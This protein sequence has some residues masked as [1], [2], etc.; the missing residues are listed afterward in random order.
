MPIS[1]ACE[2][3]NR[4]LLSEEFAGEQVNCPYCGRDLKPDFTPSS[5]PSSTSS[6]TSANA[7]PTSS[8]RTTNKSNSV[9]PP[10]L[11]GPTAPTPSQPARTPMGLQILIGFAV[12]AAICSAVFLRVEGPL[13]GFAIAAPAVLVALLALAM[14]FGARQSLAVS[15]VAF[16]F[17]STMASMTFTEPGVLDRL[18]AM[19]SN[20]AVDSETNRSE[21]GKPSGANDNSASKTK[22]QVLIKTN[23]STPNPDASVNSKT[24]G[25]DPNGVNVWSPS[26]ESIRR[27]DWEFR[28]T[29]VSITKPRV[30]NLLESSNKPSRWEKAGLLVQ[31]EV[32]N[33]SNSRR[34]DYKLFRIQL[35][36]DVRNRCERVELG[37][38]RLADRNILSKPLISPGQSLSDMFF[39]DEP[40][41]K[42][43]HLDLDI[44]AGH[45]D[46]GDSVRIRIP[47]GLIERESITEETPKP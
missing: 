40:G 18:I 28:L 11:Q 2:C 16:L 19:A 21:D 17:C 29:R 13:W 44:D 9:V 34:Y 46:F 8:A 1:V 31:L 37:S 38:F 47:V 30:F 33:H 12:I 10:F 14:A 35:F 43:D 15:F 5:A 24:G 20:R 23:S 4:M 39:F 25:Q 7:P 3:G 45:A 42:V 22:P 26:G 36:D 32:Q 27:G 41:A 6:T